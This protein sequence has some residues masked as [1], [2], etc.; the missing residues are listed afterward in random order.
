MKNVV[1]LGVVL[2]CV[3]CGCKD[4]VP[5]EVEHLLARTTSLAT[6]MAWN[7]SYSLIC[8][9]T[10]AHIESMG[11]D[12][13]R[14]LAVRQW[15]SNLETTSP[16]YE[17]APD[18][19]YFRSV[20]RYACCVD[21]VLTAIERIETDKQY[22]LTKSSLLMHRVKTFSF[23]TPLAQLQ[24]EMCPP[25]SEEWRGTIVALM[26][27]YVRLSKRWKEY[28][29][30]TLSKG[31]DRCTA[32]TFKKACADLF[33]NAKRADGCLVDVGS[34]AKSKPPRMKILH[35]PPRPLEQIVTNV[36]ST[37]HRLDGGQKET[38]QERRETPDELRA[39]RLARIRENARVSKTVARIDRPHVEESPKSQKPGLS[40]VEIR[41]LLNQGYQANESANPYCLF[42]IRRAIEQKLMG[43]V[44]DIECSGVVTMSV[45][46]DSRG[47]VR[48]VLL[49]ESCGNRKI[50]QKVLL[51]M[52]SIKRI[53]GLNDDFTSAYRN[54]P[55]ILRYSVGGGRSRQ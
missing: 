3:L 50:D 14:K 19:Q 44:D 17:R 43:T 5:E 16:R 55:L 34:F 13:S 49:E 53:D 42:L 22:R 35:E 32:R 45:N 2:L 46:F 36:A 26:D 51:A 40:D 23:L 10:L 6:N 4:R 29:V 8:D 41:N 52:R 25:E 39:K 21:Y 30:P 33:I 7:G 47:K 28:V 11:S 24:E 12:A 38:R 54:D 20:R 37:M 31:L 27:E 15:V 9:E 18:M 1:S 48:R